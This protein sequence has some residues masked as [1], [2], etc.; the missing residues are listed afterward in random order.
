MP[1]LFYA[2]RQYFHLDV[3]IFEAAPKFREGGASVGIHY[4]A[5]RALEL[6]SPDAVAYLEAA[7]A[8]KRDGFTATMAVGEDQGRTR[9]RV[10]E[11]GGACAEHVVRSVSR[12]GVLRML[13]ADAPPLKLHT[14]KQLSHH[15][16]RSDGSLILHLYVRCLFQD[17]HASHSLGPPSH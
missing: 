5:F 9:A 6:I 11:D 10:G 8:F 2:L 7:G 16:T 13:L 3:H 12:A 15:E 4:N 14:S 17:H 1:T